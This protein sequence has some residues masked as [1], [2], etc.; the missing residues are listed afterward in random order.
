LKRWP[1][2]R[3]LTSIEKGGSVPPLL[4]ITGDSGFLIERAV[5]ALVGLIPEQERSFCLWRSSATDADPV[6]LL[7]EASTLPMWG[8]R[9]V[10]LVRQAE[11]LALEGHAGWERYFH[12][13]C[14]STVVGFVAT[15]GA[16]S[17]KLRRLAQVS[18]LVECRTPYARD[19]AGWVMAEAH[20]LGCAVDRDAAAWMV[21][22]AG[23]DLAALFAWME[24]CLTYR[25]SAGKLERADLEAVSGRR[26]PANLFAWA[27]RVGEGNLSEALRLARRAVEDGEDPLPLLSR[28]ANH[29]RRLARLKGAL[30]AGAPPAEAAQRAGVPPF[31]VRQM[32]T[33][34]RSRTDAEL[35]RALASCARA[36]RA[37]KSVRVSSPRVLDRW[38]LETRTGGKA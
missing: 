33:Q 21:E 37:L 4:L 38:L 23:R 29:L 16:D 25:G 14:A 8:S 36:D 5:Q 35:A 30:A 13:P 11:K 6:R 18:T 27:D 32:V 20:A 17:K 9:R 26:S 1:L 15:P 3:L 19:V 10:I 28:A 31:L 24:R 22:V 12:Q 2:E 34:A 7:E